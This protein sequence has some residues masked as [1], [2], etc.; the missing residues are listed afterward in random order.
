M[1]IFEFF[2]FK[3]K[4]SQFILYFWIVVALLLFPHVGLAK[5]VFYGVGNDGYFS[6]VVG[7]GAALSD[8]IGSDAF[9]SYTYSNLAGRT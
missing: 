4:C 7:M 5:T 6:D 3:N 9:T 8:A 1:Q 2:H